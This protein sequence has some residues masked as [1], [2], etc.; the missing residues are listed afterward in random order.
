M[1]QK[2]L[3]YAAAVL[4]LS[5][6]SGCASGGR[7]HRDHEENPAVWVVEETQ[8]KERDS[9][10][11]SKKAAES[12]RTI[13]EKALEENALGSVETLRALA[14]RLGEQG[15]A[16]VDGENG[17][18]IDM[19]HPELVEA[20]CGKVEEEEDAEVTIFSVTENGGF[21]RFDLQTSEGKVHVTRSVL[22]WENGE[23]EVVYRKSFPAARW[24]YTKEGWLFFDEYQPEGYD[25]APGYTALRVKPLDDLRKCFRSFLR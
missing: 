16:A 6:L 11:E 10:E 18:Q 19:V 3:Q 17:N 2:A 22:A 1:N 7:F 20:F 13:Y 8:E 25:G 12:C 9:T 21:I 4:T 23:P 15:Y 14:E 5:V 24:E